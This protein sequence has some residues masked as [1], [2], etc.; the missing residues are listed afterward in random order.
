MIAELE[1]K[2]A[3]DPEFACCSCECLYQRKNVTAFEF[4]ESKKFT[5]GMWNTLRLYMYMYD[6][7]APDK[8]HYMCQLGVLGHRRG[9]P[10]R[11][12]EAN[13]R[14]NQ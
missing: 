10:Q 3:D 2:L 6:P 5:S 8:V 4:S 11:R 14:E 7:D 1:K 12:I 9:Q 13:N